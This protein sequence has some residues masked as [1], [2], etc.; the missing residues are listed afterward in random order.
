MTKNKVYKTSSGGPIVLLIVSV[1]ILTIILTNDASHVDIWLSW[2]YLAIL[3]L[4]AV[5]FKFGMYA[6]NR[7]GIFLERKHFLYERRIPIADIDQILYQ[8]TWKLGQ[9]MRSIYFMDKKDNKIKIRMSN[10]AYPHATLAQIL[11]DLTRENSAIRLDDPA[12]HL[13][14]KYQMKA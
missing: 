6:E 3:I 9:K 8:P 4:G 11:Q 12:R 10:G 13:R 14:N 7:D 5:D 2:A 1:V